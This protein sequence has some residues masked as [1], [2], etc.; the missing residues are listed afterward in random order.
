[1]NKAG[2]LAHNRGQAGSGNKGKAVQPLGGGG[3]GLTAPTPPFTSFFGA[4]SRIFAPAFFG[5]ILMSVTSSGS[6]EFF[7]FMALQV[8]QGDGQRKTFV[9]CPL[10]SRPGVRRSRS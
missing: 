7:D 2:R 10:N 6:S 1:M 9:H 4:K 3:G 5:L 8:E